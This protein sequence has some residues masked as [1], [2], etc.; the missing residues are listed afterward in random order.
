MKKIITLGEIMLRLSP[1]NRDKF[2]GT[3]SFQANY[4]GGEANVAVALAN[5]GIETAFVSKLPNNEIGDSAINHLRS[6]GV[7]TSSVVR[8]GDRVG[9]YFL[10][11]GFSLRN[12]KVIYDRKDSAIS[13]ALISDFEIESI[14]KG[15]DIL[16]LSGI[17]LGISN[18]GFEISKAFMKKA[19][20]LG[21]EISFDFNYRSKLWSLE[22]AGK[23][24][25]EILKYVDIA[26]AGHLDFT[27]I[28]RIVPEQPLEKIDLLEYYKDLYQ[29]VNSKYNFK[30]IVSSIRDVKSASNNT[31][32]GICYD[33][34]TI[35]R[36][37]SYE[38]DIIDRVGTGDAYTAGFL[39]GYAMQKEIDY[40]INIATAS[41]VLK[42]TISGD[43][44]LVKLAEVEE[45]FKKDSFDVKR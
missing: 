16:H 44:T 21:M 33:G 15:W 20:E 2:L 31:Y 8:G 28:L 1:P 4:G 25:H 45:L 36:S 19:K 42:H 43:V 13:T 29:K 24:I 41:S 30:Y 18:N 9:I 10:E 37:K 34:K 6:F 5:Y 40:T 26:F 3:P 22:D 14:L 35:Y 38:V 39:C 17:T 23:K 11:N 32:A 12:S 7:N 27:N